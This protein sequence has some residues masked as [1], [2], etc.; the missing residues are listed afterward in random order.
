MASYKNTAAAAATYLHEMTVVLRP[1]FVMPVLCVFPH[2]PII[3]LQCSL[4]WWHVEFY[5]SHVGVR[6]SRPNPIAGC[7]VTKHTLQLFAHLQW[8]KQTNRSS[9]FLSFFNNKIRAFKLQKGKCT[10]ELKVWVVKYPTR[11]LEEHLGP[12]H[13]CIWMHSELNT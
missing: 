7:F 9:N 11:G 4:I 13:K 5:Q 8:C 1:E 12:G 10:R 2:Q 6:I 3:L